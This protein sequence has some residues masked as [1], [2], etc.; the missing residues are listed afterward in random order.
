MRYAPLNGADILG[1]PT[2]RILDHRHTSADGSVRDA[3]AAALRQ[4]VLTAGDATRV[5][6]RVTITLSTLRGHGSGTEA[7]QQGSS[8][9]RWQPS[10]V[11]RSLGLAALAACAE[12]SYRS[13]GQAVPAV[14]DQAVTAWNR[15][16][17]LRFH[18]EPWLAGL[19]PGGR[20]AVL[21]EAISWASALWSMVDWPRL[22]G[23]TT[24]GG[25]GRPVD[26]FA[27]PGRLP[28]RPC[29]SAASEQPKHYSGLSGGPRPGR[30]RAHL[31]RRRA[32]DSELGGRIGLSRACRLPAVPRSPGTRPGRRALA[33]VGPMQDRRG[34]RRP[35][36][37][38]LSPDGRGRR[39]VGPRRTPGPELEGGRLTR[40]R[41][42]PTNGPTAPGHPRTGSRAPRLSGGVRGVRGVLGHAVEPPP[43]HYRPAGPPGSNRGTGWT[44]QEAG[45]ALRFRNRRPP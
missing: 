13:P 3:T 22:G 16:G 39:G 1:D 26:R 28:T 17:E 40:D 35:P 7:R 37:C 38:S 24:F 11:R 27:S 8:P 5:D 30:P 25:S 19:G 44:A 42:C 45:S 6:R 41:G 36:A 43:R 12:S 21:A 34:G 14:A 23:R 20:A 9:F 4:A 10:F 32:P 33:C 15:T 18:W 31:G 29:R 2:E